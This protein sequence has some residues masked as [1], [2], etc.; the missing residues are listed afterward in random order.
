MTHQPPP[1]SVLVPCVA[2]Q[3]IGNY[4]LAATFAAIAGAVP[5][6]S[7][8]EMDGVSL[9][10]LLTGNDSYGSTKKNPP[11]KTLPSPA[12]AGSIQ[13]AGHLLVILPFC[14]DY[15]AAAPLTSPPDPI[16]TRHFRT[17]H[18][19]FL[20]LFSQRCTTPCAWRCALPQPLTTAMPTR[21]GRTPALDIGGHR[22]TFEV[23]AA[24]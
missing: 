12:L 15:V 23:T 20:S 4:D 6:S 13:S 18:L 3:V 7:A 22:S 11:K 21:E 2:I 9:L 16:P 17:H 5:T 14:A 1:S 19:K 10:P 24:Q 8:P